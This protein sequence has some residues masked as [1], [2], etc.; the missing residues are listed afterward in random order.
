MIV[1]RWAPDA[2][3]AV[4]LA[5]AGCG[6]IGPEA[7]S[8]A[9]GQPSADGGRADDNASSD[10]TASNYRVACRVLTGLGACANVRKERLERQVHDEHYRPG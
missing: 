4:V 7:N 2:A 9:L 1:V 6:G 8:A 3:L 10:L 5:L